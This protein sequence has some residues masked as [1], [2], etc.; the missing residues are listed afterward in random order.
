[1]NSPVKQMFETYLIYGVVALLA[2]ELFCIGLLILLFWISKRSQEYISWKYI[3][4]PEISLKK[5]KWELDHTLQS[6]RDKI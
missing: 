5:V 3:D 6:F 2:A 4:T 1:M